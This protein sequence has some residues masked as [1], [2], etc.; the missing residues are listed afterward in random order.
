MSSEA[1]DVTISFNQSISD[2]LPDA[3]STISS[4]DTNVTEIPNEIPAEK[5]EETDNTLTSV[6]CQ[7]CKK[8]FAQPNNLRRHTLNVHKKPFEK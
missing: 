5:E 1:T 8:Y 3:S 2:E 4:E 6:Y 7:L